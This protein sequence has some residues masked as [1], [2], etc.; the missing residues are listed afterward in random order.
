MDGFVP[1][2]P[3]PA[4]VQQHVI[5]R[6]AAAS[7]AMAMFYCSDNMEAEELFAC[8]SKNSSTSMF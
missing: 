5:Q 2:A 7:T 6:V 8:A 1:G 4:L 3:G